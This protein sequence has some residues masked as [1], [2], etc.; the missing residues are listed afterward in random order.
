MDTYT[1]C[2]YA[3]LHLAQVHKKAQLTSACLPMLATTAGC[4]VLGM[5][6]VGMRAAADGVS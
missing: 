4:A 3:W 1:S 5:L 2:A 6:W